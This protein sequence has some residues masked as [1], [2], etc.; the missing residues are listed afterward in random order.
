MHYT[1]VSKDKPLNIFHKVQQ[2]TKVLKETNF[3]VYGKLCLFT[4][5]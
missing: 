2:E 1:V 4:F 5:Q 3:I